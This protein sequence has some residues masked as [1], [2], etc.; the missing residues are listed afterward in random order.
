MPLLAN[1]ALSAAL[2]QML[3]QNQAKAQQVLLPFCLFSDT[4]LL[5][6]QPVLI[7]P[8]PLVHTFPPLLSALSLFTISK[9]FWEIIFC[10]LRCC[11]IKKTL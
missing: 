8:L 2:L 5:A 1:P 6:A 3:L 7:H 4:S 9:P 11:T 10:G